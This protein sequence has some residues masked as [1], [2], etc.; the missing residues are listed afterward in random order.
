MPAHCPP[1]RCV[2]GGLL[3]PQVM[4]S[5]LRIFNF[6]WKLKRVEYS[7]TSTWRRHMTTSRMTAS[8]P[9]TSGLELSD[10]R[11]DFHKGHLLRNE[12][13]HFVYN[14]QYYMMFEVAETSWEV[15]RACAYA[16]SEHC[17]HACD[18]CHGR[19]S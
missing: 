16:P 14:L 18:N 11:K 10:L 5:Y 3:G 9:L 12:M 1:A 2:S 15:Q 13:I 19:A 7:L 8:R 4:E 6:L 17:Q